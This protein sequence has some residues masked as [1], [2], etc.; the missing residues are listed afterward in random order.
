MARIRSIKPDFWTDEKVVELSAFARLLFIGLWN[1]ADDD[2]R[3]VY[4]PVKIKLQILPA[5]TLN[6]SELIGEIRGK[7]MVDIYAI[8][9]IEYLQINNFASHQK[10]DKRT[11]SKY[12][13]PAESPRIPPTE[14]KGREGN[15]REGK[16]IQRGQAA[17]IRP[18]E[19][20]E[21]VWNDFLAIRKAKR[22]PLT[23]T[24]LYGIR[25]EADRAG[26]SLTQAIETCCVRGW[27]GFQ[28][29]WV[30][31]TPSEGFGKTSQAI[32]LLENMKG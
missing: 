5:D 15:G 22:A 10:I 2:G 4:S 19:V 9:G 14:G 1:F 21:K 30:E 20:P 12:P 29:R 16:G 28:A 31:T 13:P 23:D 17:C 24:A 8:D 27:Q 3:M 11:A 32:A 18:D 25:A 6:I 7:S 26:Y